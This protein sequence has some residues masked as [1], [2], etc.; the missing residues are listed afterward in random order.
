VQAA[1]LTRVVPFS[2]NGV[3]GPFVVEGHEPGP[4]EVAQDSWLRSVTPGY[5][6]AMRMP[7]LRGRSFQPSD[8]KTSLPV[9]VVDEK[10]A[11]MYWPQGDPT[12]KRIR[13]GGGP[14]MTIVGVVPSVKN[15]KLDENTKPYVYLPAAQWVSGD[16]SL[17]VRSLNDPAALIPAIRQQ[18]ASL[19]PELPFSGVRTLEQAVARTLSAKRL[20]NLLFATFAVTALLLAIIGIYGVM[21]LNIG[22]RTG[23]FG[24]RMALGA[25]SRDVL[26]LVL[27]QGM[28]LTVVGVLAGLGGALALM[29]LMKTLFFG[30]SATDPLTFIAIA[31][32]M[33][34]V[35]LLAC[36]LPARRATRVD[37]MVALRHE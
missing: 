20:T 28:K 19:D 3:G 30:V 13:I 36:Y 18:L 7:V 16:M 32:L 2:G 15:R 6:A 22:S 25:Q 29:R 23:E 21:S 8:T 11:R 33:T 5:F 1:E 35:A 24:I 10:L 4:G 31:A 26:K 14:W 9:T 27:G 34:F 37:P 12:G 17:V